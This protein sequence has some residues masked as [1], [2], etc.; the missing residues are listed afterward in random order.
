MTYMTSPYNV[1]FITGSTGRIGS[2]ISQGL[3]HRGYQIRHL[4]LRMNDSEIDFELESSMRAVGYKILIHVAGHN[5]RKSW[6]QNT[7]SY[8]ATLYEA[9]EQLFERVLAFAESRNFDML[10]VI[11]STK[12]E[13]QTLD[14]G[15]SRLSLYGKSKLQ[16]E[17]MALAKQPVSLRTVIIR[18]APFFSFKSRQVRFLR[19]LINTGIPLVTG[20]NSNRRRYCT[21]YSLIRTIIGVLEHRHESNEPKLLT[22]AVPIC[23]STQGIFRLIARG[24][25]RKLTSVP[26]PPRLANCL[27]YF[28][29]RSLFDFL[30]RSH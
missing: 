11:S 20:S 15:S 5:G 21:K 16:V 3:Q 9:N 25:K 28:G 22:C 17:H 29:L 24:S 7:K 1:I 23:R 2:V 18:L 10:V 26:V 13:G 6:F 8:A 19:F 30:Y 14:D 27:D 12:V 4:N